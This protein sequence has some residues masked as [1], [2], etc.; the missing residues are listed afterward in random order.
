MVRDSAAHIERWPK[1]AAAWKSAAFRYWQKGTPGVR[2]F[3]SP[4][5]FWQWWIDRDAHLPSEYEQRLFD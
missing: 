3:E 2:K 5:S 4:E 1:I